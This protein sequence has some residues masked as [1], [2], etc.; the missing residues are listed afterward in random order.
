L[1]KEATNITILERLVAWQAKRRQ[2]KLFLLACDVLRDIRYREVEL[3]SEDR[4]G[5]KARIG[6]RLIGVDLAT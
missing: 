4:E 1:E 2:R 6:I 3:V 5:N